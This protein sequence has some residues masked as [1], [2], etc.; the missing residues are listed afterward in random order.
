MPPVSVAGPAG[1]ALRIS[2]PG[3]R[4]SRARD[5]ESE[6]AI[7]KPRRLRGESIMSPRGVRAAAIAAIVC[8]AATAEAGPYYLWMDVARRDG[9]FT[10]W[11]TKNGV[12]I[13]ATPENPQGV[14]CI[15][16]DC[17]A[18]DTI[19]VSADQD[20][21]NDLDWRWTNASGQS[22]NSVA[23]AYSQPGFAAFLPSLGGE[24]SWLDLVDAGGEECDI[25]IDLE[26]WGDFLRTHPLPDPTALIEFQIGVSAELPGYFVRD[27]ASGTPFTGSMVADGVGSLASV[28]AVP[29]QSAGAT[30]VLAVLLLGSGL[31]VLRRRRAR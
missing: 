8:L 5:R 29:G 4:A 28:G 22:S 18:G 11:W 14:P 13:T 25:D 26:L 6:A 27:T 23:H 3:E 21:A 15:D 2:L 20:W 17:V 7:S 31:L 30:A 10:G 19:R 9:H 12:R 1:E 16:M 24:V